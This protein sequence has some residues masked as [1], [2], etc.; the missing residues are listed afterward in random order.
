MYTVQLIQACALLRLFPVF[1]TFSTLFVIQT[2]HIIH[3]CQVNLDFY[4]VSPSHHLFIES[5]NEENIIS[6]SEPG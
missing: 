4:H 3:A 5:Q 1:L 2:T 6:D